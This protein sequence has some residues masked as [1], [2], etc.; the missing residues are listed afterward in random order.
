MK[1]QSRRELL[2]S[3]GLI[4]ISPAF[5]KIPVISWIAPVVQEPDEVMEC[6]KYSYNYV[7][8]GEIWGLVNKKNE[9]I[10][11]QCGQWASVV[12]FYYTKKPYDGSGFIKYEN[13]DRSLYPPVY[14]CA[15]C[16]VDLEV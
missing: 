11:C 4:A 13:M 2:R 14:T 5:L 6:P 15:D 16:N 12:C 9:L 10:L 1:K 3:L 7:R 8:F